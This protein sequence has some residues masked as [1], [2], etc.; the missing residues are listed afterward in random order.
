M[1]E[2]KMLLKSDLKPQDNANRPKP[3]KCQS[4]VDA[5]PAQSPANKGSSNFTPRHIPAAQGWDH[6]PSPPHRASALRAAPISTD[7]PR[8]LQPLQTPGRGRAACHS[9]VHGLLPLPDVA[10]VADPWAG[11]L[12]IHL[13]V[14][15]IHKSAR[16]Q[17]R[18]QD[19]CFPSLCSQDHKGL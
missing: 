8:L 5:D 2:S 7:V 10:L 19:H 3:G 4:L 1:L 16:M 18:A 11:F 6:A 14:T 15:L 17:M 13:L 9:H 12:Q